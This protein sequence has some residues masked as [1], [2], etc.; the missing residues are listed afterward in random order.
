M[1]LLTLLVAG[2]A[3]STELVPLL[4]AAGIP[5]TEPTTVPLRVVTRSTA[6][7]DPLHVRG[8]AVAYGD[9]EAALGYAVS[10]AT[11]PWAEGHRAHPK[12][13]DGWQLNVEITNDEASFED[14]RVIFAIAVRA[15]LWAR[16]GNI[17]LAQT[18]ASCRQGGMGEPADGAPIMYRCMMEIGRQLAGWLDGV[19]LEAGGPR[20]TMTS[21][22]D[23]YLDKNVNPGVAPLAPRRCLHG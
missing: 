19:D 7:E 18:Q 15:T 6:V 16:A 11:V 14:H 5:I 10:S 2:C 20:A 22:P 23:C 3:R 1:A 8:A 12:S 21:V 9:I 13:G 4:T 17:Y